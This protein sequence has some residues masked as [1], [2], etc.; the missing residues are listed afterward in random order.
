M[1]TRAVS[2]VVEWN[3]LKYQ[4]SF[5]FEDQSKLI[6]V[7]PLKSVSTEME[8]ERNCVINLLRVIIQ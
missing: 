7:C 6:P 2:T 5:L 8:A 4:F 3:E 1:N